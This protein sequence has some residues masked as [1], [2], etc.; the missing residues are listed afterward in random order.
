MVLVTMIDKFKDFYIAEYQEQ[1][2]DNIAEIFREVYVQTYP[3]FDEKFHKLKRFQ[4]ILS[5]YTLPKSQ[6][7]TA[8]YN[9]EVVGFLALQKNCIDQ[10]YILNDFQNKGLGNFW[11]NQAKS[12]YSDF[13]E[14]YTLDCNKKAIAFYEKHGFKIVEKGIAPDEKMPDVKMRWES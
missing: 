12:I 6:V 8:K 9:S 11:I 4:T 3:H 1:D 7:W 5:E 14:L 10:I 13:L 2:V